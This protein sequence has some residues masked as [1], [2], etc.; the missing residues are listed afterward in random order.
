M[1]VTVFDHG[2]GNLHSLVKAL[3]LGG[4]FVRVETVPALAVRDTDALILPGVGAFGPAAERMAP[5][6][7]ANPRTAARPNTRECIRLTPS[8]PFLQSR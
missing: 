6:R 3:E 5:G 4:A 8:P 1:K 7:N 2:A